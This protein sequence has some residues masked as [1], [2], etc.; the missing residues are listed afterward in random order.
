MSAFAA[1]AWDIDGTLI[2]SEPLHQETLGTVCRRYGFDLATLPENAFLG[3]H[4]H[5]VW[6]ALEPRFTAPIGREAWM[7]EL[8]GT[9]VASTSRL[10][11]QPGALE[12]LADLGRR[13]LKQVCVSNSNRP[14]VDANIAALGI[15]EMIEFSLS[16]DDVA[17]GKPDPEPYRTACERLGVAP[18]NAAAVEDSPTGAASARAAGLYVVGY[19]PFG[20]AIPEAHVTV[21]SLSELWPSLERAGPI[22]A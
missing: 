1:I 3:V 19:N 17:R 6:A 16:F 20:A 22:G 12:V 5:D 11:P 18:A 13:G 8:I 14:V 9:Y 15:L 2:D 7:A 21:Q 10:V 4:I